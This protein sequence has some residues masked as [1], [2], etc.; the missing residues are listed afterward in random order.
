MQLSLMDGTGNR[1][2]VLDVFRECLPNDDALPSLARELCHPEAGFA[3]D[4]LLIAEP[5]EG[6][7]G[8]M[9]VYNAD[10]SIAE[11]CGNGLRCVGKLLFDRR[12]LGSVFTVDTGAGPRTIE[13]FSSSEEISELRTGLGKPIVE[14]AAIPTLLKGTPPIEQPIVLEGET[15]LVTCVSMGNPHAVTFVDDPTR[16]A[17][18]RIGP[19]IEHHAAF[20]NRTNVEFA[21]IVSS[22]EIRLRVWER[23]VGETAACGTGAAATTAAAILTGRTGR[24]VTVHL[25]GGDLQISWP[26]DRSEIYLTGPAKLIDVL[27]WEPAAMSSRRSTPSNP[28][29]ESSHPIR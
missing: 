12:S 21:S 16:I 22:S 10:G 13:V 17:V 4:G 26:D 25:P 2:L 3:V 28:V 11:M 20:P 1:F 27:N 14:A 23:G 9:R 18:D 15:W 29:V 24:E 5:A 19:Q 7:A 6:F 8:R